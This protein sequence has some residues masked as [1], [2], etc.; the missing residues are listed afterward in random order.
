MF[1]IRRWPNSSST[2][3]YSSLHRYRVSTSSPSFQSQRDTTTKPEEEG[4][5][6]KTRNRITWM[7]IKR[8]SRGG[9]NLSER[10]KRL[11]R[12]LR[13]KVELGKDTGS[14]VRLTGK[15]S[16]LEKT[17]EDIMIFRGVEI[18]REPKAPES[19]G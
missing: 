10:Y 15:R 1:K 19:E 16:G 18:R 11:E 12:S 3:I 13:G 7:V 9:Q 2:T 14:E 6:S 8:G 4:T 5:V 17:K